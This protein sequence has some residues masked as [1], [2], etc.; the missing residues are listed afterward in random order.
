MKFLA[1]RWRKVYRDMWSNKSRT[2]LVV[3]SIAVGVIAVGIVS[4]SQIV[5][6]EA[7]NSTY[8]ASNPASGHVITVDNFDDDL[9]ATIDRMREVERA[10]GRR[11]F[12]L[13]YQLNGQGEWQTIQLIAYEDYDEVE[14]NIQFP[15]QGEWP[16]QDRQ[17]VMERAGLEYMGAQVGDFVTVET[18]EG[19]F[20]TLQIVGTAHAQSGPPASLIGQPSGFINRDTLEWLNEPLDYNQMRFLVA[21]N[22]DDR[23]HIEDVGDLIRNKIENAN[24]EV[25]RVLV[26]NPGEHP[27]NVVFVSVLYILTALG[28]L[29]VILS[30]FLVI[31]TIS[32]ILTQQKRQIGIMK[33]IG[34]RQGDIVKLYFVTV[35]IYGLLALVVAIPTSIFGAVAFTNFMADFFNTDIG[36]FVFPKSVMVMQ[37]AISLLVPMLASIYPILS[38]T[39]VTVR[40]AISDFGLGKGQFGTSL[41]DRILQTIRGL[42][43]PL[44]ISLRNTFRRKSRLILT[45]V[46]LTLAGMTFV[47]V[48]SLRDSIY[49]TIQQTEDNWNYDFEINFEQSYRLDEINRLMGQQSGLTA[50]EGWSSRAVTRVRP[51]GRES[52]SFTLTAVPAETEMLQPTLTEGRWLLPD[53]ANALVISGNILQD[54]PDLRVG[55]D[56]VLKVGDKDITWRIVGT[57]QGTLFQSNIYAN[58]PY[59]VQVIHDVNKADSAKFTTTTSNVDEQAEIALALEELFEDSGLEVSQTRLVGDIVGPASAALDFLTVL[60]MFMA[61]VMA[62]VGALGLAGTMSINVLERVRE[63]GVMRAIGASDGSILRMVIIEGMII[64]TLSWL[65]AIVIALPLSL[66]VSNELGFLLLSTPLSFVYSTSGILIWLITSIILAA[67][68]SFLPARNASQLTVR[69][70]LSYE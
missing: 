1:P 62:I 50:V 28:I 6:S 21:E 4:G 15:K 42:S 5:L 19:K 41:I 57:V 8:T 58:H 54:E 29:S 45:L 36:E 56:V 23:E 53:D 43:R 66:I 39:R 14:L 22:K 25:S 9:V 11:Q 35:V 40:E 44:M 61:V 20:R 31:N 16:P 18:S 10:E 63:I 47:T 2:L 67:I 49:A 12:T 17:I 3:L 59:Y 37:A 38:G 13:L 33:S 32:A 64:G 46:T 52:D 70:V 7:L 69:E 65:A 27:V 68:A 51:N 26:P 34:A 24:V 30:G 60:L 55:D 48:F